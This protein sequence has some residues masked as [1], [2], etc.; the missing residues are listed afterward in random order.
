[1]PQHGKYDHYIKLKPDAPAKINCRVYPMSLKEDEQLDKFIDENLRLQRIKRTDSP[2][3]S[4]CFIKKK[5]EK[6]QPV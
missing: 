6:L 2:Y 4:G 3:T 5:D 1:M